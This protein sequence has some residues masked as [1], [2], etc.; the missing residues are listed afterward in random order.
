MPSGP[1]PLAPLIVISRDGAGRARRQAFLRS[2]VRIG[3]DPAGELALDDPHVSAR[4]GVLE[5][6]DA[7]VRYTDLGSRN[8]SALDGR[9]V[10]PH[11]PV[12]V[13]PGQ[14]LALGAVRL[15]FERAP[16]PRREPERRDEARPGRDTI[17]PGAVTAML[18]ALARAPAVDAG[19]AWAASLHPGLRVGRFELVQELGRGGFGVVYE[20]RD[21]QLGRR[22]A[23]KAMR[24]GGAL[25]GAAGAGRDG[26]LREAEAAAQL[27]HP[28]VVQLHDAGAWGGGP[29]LIY[30]LLRG[31]ALAD[32]LLR[33]PLP[34]AE[35]LRVAVEVGRALAHAHAAGVVHRDLKPSNVFLTEEGWVKVLDFGLAHVL[36]GAGRIEGGTPRYMAPE[37]ARRAAPAAAADVFSAAVV[38]RETWLGPGVEDLRCREPGPLPGAPPPLEDLLARALE[39]DPARRPGDG[40]AWLEGLLAAGQAVTK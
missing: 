29:F 34:P 15:A 27:S 1:T 26:L 17:Q 32:R 40:R 20:A 38:L 21:L 30:E 23:F 22:V 24:P 9:A 31:E 14:E 16:S 6:D 13:A 5:F 2:P 39:E 36:G 37:Q 11:A 7:E 10:P 4:H 8:G 12:R 18:L 33:G 19:E 28:N 35:A 3:R 25:D